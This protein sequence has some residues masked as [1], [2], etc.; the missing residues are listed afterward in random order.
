MR[1]WIRIT[2][3]VGLALLLVVTGGLFLVWKAFQQMPEFYREAMAVTP[4]LHDEAGDEMIQRA[5][6][7]A[8]DGEQEDRWNAMFARATALAGDREAT[9]VP[10][11][12]Q[13]EASDGEQEGRWNALFAQATALASRPEATEVPPASQ[14]EASDEMIQRATRPSRNREA[15]EVPPASQEAPA[16]QEEAANGEQDGRWNALFTAEEI[17]DWLAVDLGKNLSSLMHGSM[18]NPRVAIEGDRLM[19]GCR[20]TR[21]NVSTVLSLSGDAYLAGRNTLAVRIRRAQAGALPLPMDRVRRRISEA[22]N[23]SGLEIQWRQS[24]GLPVALISFPIARSEA[25]RL[26]WIDTLRLGKG[27]VYLSGSTALP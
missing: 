3:S 17:N 14:E 16:L 19:V 23:R 6:A 22:A 20:L 8:S 9:E 15:T 4:G 13:E 25:N 27:E 5:T 10:P 7:P 18:S 26:M 11:A 2:V 1:K 21:G 12:L 24:G